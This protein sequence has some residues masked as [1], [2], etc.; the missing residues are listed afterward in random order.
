MQITFRTHN[1]KRLTGTGLTG[2]IALPVQSGTHPR[3][4]E[5][6]HVIAP[7]RHVVNFTLLMT[8]IRCFD[9]LP[10]PP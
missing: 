6:I 2:V 5:R 4:G 3:L 7:H 9:G 1:G 10:D 8:C